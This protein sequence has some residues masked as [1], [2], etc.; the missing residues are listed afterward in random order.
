MEKHSNN[1]NNNNWGTQFKG[2][3][4]EKKTRV[5]FLELSARQMCQENVSLVNVMYLDG[6]VFEIGEKVI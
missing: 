2:L 6:K 3:R 4:Y 5:V 1:N